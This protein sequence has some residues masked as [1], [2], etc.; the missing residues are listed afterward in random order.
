MLST[1]FGPPDALWITF[2]VWRK[3][4]WRE[5]LGTSKPKKKTGWSEGYPLIHSPYYYYLN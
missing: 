3:V 2:Y 1:T 5:G 4:A